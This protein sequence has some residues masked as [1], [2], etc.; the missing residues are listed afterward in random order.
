MNEP[1]APT[2][3]R[4]EPRASELSLPFWDATRDERLLVQWCTTCDS[5]IFYPREACP[6]CLGTD[7]T[8]R[9]AAGDATVYAV[10]IQHAPGN[11]TMID[12]VPYV[13]ALVELPEGIR[14]MTNIVTDDPTSVHVGDRV[15]VCWES[16]SDGRKL[17]QFEPVDA[18]Q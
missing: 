4:L 8:W 10:S 15:T 1:P 11:P 13:V 6:H 3:T 17:P 2:P 16:L 5:A 14:M 12:R 18:P 9:E 7:L